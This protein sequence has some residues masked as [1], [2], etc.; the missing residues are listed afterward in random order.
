MSN[1]NRPIRHG[2]N[3]DCHR[4]ARLVAS[5]HDDR[6]VSNPNKTDLRRARQHTRAIFAVIGK[7]LKEYLNGL[8]LS[9]VTD[10]GRRV[11][12]RIT[13]I[14]SGHLSEDLLT[15]LEERRA[16]T[17]GRGFR[18]AMSKMNQATTQGTLDDF[19][20]AT[21]FGNADR[22]LKDRLK[23]VDAGLLFGDDD[24][25]AEE[26]G[27]DITRQLQ[28]GVRS[29]E[30]VQEL[31]ERVDMV[32]NDGDHPARREKGVSGMTKRTKGELI[33]HDSIQ[34][35]FNTAARKRYAQNGFRFV[36]YEA[37]IDTRTTDLCQRMAGEVFD[38]L[39]N[40]DLQ[41]PNHP[42]CRS[43]I[44]PVLDPDSVIDVDDIAGDYL[45]TIGQTNAYRPPVPVDDQF[46]PTA[47]S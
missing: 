6:E 17:M 40:P 45:G 38:I 1:W 5:T 13:D 39:E 29:G 4:P 10:E 26:I 33:A 44:A 19:R 11:N 43:G 18:D 23:N 20:G 35:S 3:C 22:D 47:L 12:D 7:D 9:L 41:P 46:Q 34:D 21:E 36:R 31:G 2:L 24:S 42:Y 28:Q 37:T 16:T 32:L 8:D 14:A 15:W 30:D 25:L 27:N